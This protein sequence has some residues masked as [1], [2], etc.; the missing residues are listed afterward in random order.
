MSPPRMWAW[1]CIAIIPSAIV[2][3][4]WLVTD[5]LPY[6]TD[7]NE[8][9]S[10][11]V[12]GQSMLH[13][14]PWA[15]AFLTDD[16]T[17]Y[18]GGAHP[19]TYTHGPNLPR[20]FSALLYLLGVQDL[21][22]QVLISAVVATLLSLWFIAQAFPEPLDNVPTG[23]RLTLGMLVGALF[24]TDFIGTLQFLGSLWRAWHFPLFWGCVWAAR[25]QPR[26]P[27][28]FVLFF[29]VFQLEFLFAIFTAVTCFFYVL[30]THRGDW[31]RVLNGAYVGMAMGAVASVAVFVTQLIVFYG[32]YG[33]LFDLQTTYV[34]R[35]TNQV[36]WE[37]IR[38]FY[39]THSVMMWPSSPN[40]DVRFPA[41][42]AVTWENMSKRL[43]TGLA[44]ATF[45]ALLLSLALAIYA[46]RLK[47][48]DRV[49]GAANESAGP[50]LWAMVAAYL[51][52][53]VAIPGYT[54]NGYT[55]RWAPL[56]VFP[57][58]LALALLVV[59]SAALAERFARV[60]AL[61]RGNLG[62]II[63]AI[64]LAIWVG[65]S[66]H[67]YLKYPD[68]IHLPATALASTYK[69][70][71][72][73][74]HT[75]FPHMIAH[76]TGRWAYYSTKIFPGTERLDQTY[77]WNA[78]RNRNPDYET[79]EYYLCEQVPYFEGIDCDDTERQMSALGHEL[80]ER[81]PG[82]VIMKLNWRLPHTK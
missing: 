23:S 45:A 16:A 59:N 34:T 70:R 64:V 39:E 80:V 66:V 27:I 67:Q 46:A 26:W 33:F 31:K 4:M 65:R 58:T 5:G 29:L 22:W 82:F 63:A 12:Q 81:G 25:T 56:L 9:F 43:S 41:Y 3:R 11:Y 37:S 40:L 28:G 24:A 17:G 48:A 42:L 75:T 74:S 15:N 44:V 57:V 1:L 18:H 47:Q 77:N 32:I 8:T 71:S 79:P 6:N 69:G 62:A 76:Y 68:F 51:L 52:L 7:S 19:F 78:D 53:G 50:L 60:P 13:F 36:T 61:P 72:F 49:A 55:V 38:D 14:N 30:W 10:A 35:N 2:F 20:Y 54:L 73:V 21:E